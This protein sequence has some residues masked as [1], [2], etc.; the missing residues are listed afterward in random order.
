MTRWWR[1][2][3]GGTPAP[4]GFDGTLE[5]EERVLASA[6]AAGGGYVVATSLGLWVP[7]AESQSGNHRRIG[8]HLV[9]KA[10][11]DGRVLTVIEADEIGTEGT[12]GGPEAVLIADRP[13]KRYHLPEPVNVPE[14]VH[15]RVTRSVLHSEHAPGGG[16]G[17]Q[18]RVPGRDGVHLQIRRPTT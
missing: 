8:W 13:P 9:S 11:W 5:G 16:L 18:R 15:A 3:L 1:R 14:I 6:A 10:N 4:D 17:V 2:L 12:D 7:Y